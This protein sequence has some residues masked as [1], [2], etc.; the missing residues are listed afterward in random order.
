MVYNFTQSA[1]GECK[2]GF[3][4]TP[5]SLPNAKY[6]SSYSGEQVLPD[7]LQIEELFSG[8]GASGCAKFLGCDLSNDAKSAGF[9]IGSG[10]F[11]P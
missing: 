7:S 9:S 4:A 8:I 1:K 5:K 11:N 3:T 2:T 10:L 6:L